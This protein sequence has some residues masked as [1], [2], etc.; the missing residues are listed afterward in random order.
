MKTDS[1]NYKSEFSTLTK[2]FLDKL[3]IN[4]T[5][6]KWHWNAWMKMKYDNY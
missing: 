4:T 2:C 6:V 3:I 1:N 5:N